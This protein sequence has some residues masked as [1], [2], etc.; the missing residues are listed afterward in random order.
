MKKMATTLILFAFVAAN[1]YGEMTCFEY[2]YR[3]GRCSTQSFLDIECD[4]EDNVSIPHRCRTKE[5]ARTQRGIEAGAQSVYD[6]LD[7]PLDAHELLK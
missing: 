3:Y 1:A 2:G 4:P 7:I 5:H 6:E